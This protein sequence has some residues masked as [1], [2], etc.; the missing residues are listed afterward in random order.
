MTSWTHLFLQDDEHKKL[1]IKKEKKKSCANWG[2]YTLYRLRWDSDGNENAWCIQ[3]TSNLTHC[4]CYLWRHFPFS[5]WGVATWNPSSISMRWFIPGH[6]CNL[7]DIRKVL[8]LV[9]GFGAN[10]ITIDYRCGDGRPNSLSSSETGVNLGIKSW[11]R[12]LSEWAQ[13]QEAIGD[14]YFTKKWRAETLK[15]RLEFGSF[16]PRLKRYLQMHLLA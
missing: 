5:C 7:F 16:K 1:G 13:R 10:A 2:G 11:W 14:I 4:S 9:T 6:N 15:P 12:H 3:I 8:V